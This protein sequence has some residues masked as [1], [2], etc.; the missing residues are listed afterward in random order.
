M[1]YWFNFSALSLSLSFSP[2]EFLEPHGGGSEVAQDAAEGDRR[3]AAFSI[4]EAE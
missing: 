1:I 3:A 4:Q 2:G